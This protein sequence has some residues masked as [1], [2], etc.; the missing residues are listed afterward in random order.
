MS[1][2]GFFGARSRA[3]SPDGESIVTS[4]EDEIL[5]LLKNFRK[6]SFSVFVILSSTDYFYRFW[7]VFSKARSQKKSKSAL[8][9]M[10]EAHLETTTIPTPVKAEYGEDPP[11]G[12]SL[13]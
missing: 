13:L 4:A 5:R 10:K 2:V 11:A 7:D 9:K 3:M 8:K 6:P 1:E 12:G